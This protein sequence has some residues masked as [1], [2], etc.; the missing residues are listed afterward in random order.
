M[1]VES[2]IAIAEQLISTGLIKKV[3]HS[4]ELIKDANRKTLYPAYQVGAEYTYS[5]IDDAK[6]LFAYIRANGD[7]TGMP[8]KVASCD[9]AYNIIQPIRVVFFNDS[10]RR[11]HE[12]LTRQLSVMAFGKGVTLSRIVTDKYR[13]VSEES[14]IFRE[15]FDGLTYYVAFDLLLTFILSRD[16]CQSDICKVYKNPVTTCP[17]AVLTS[18][19]SAIS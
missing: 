10:E 3:F 9:K 2:Q 12:E 5:G 18:S 4:C 6:G 1:I 19:S 17:A 11:N 15:K 16:V 14:D 8:F 7:Y 13:L